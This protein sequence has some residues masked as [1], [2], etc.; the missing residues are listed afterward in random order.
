[1][2][3]SLFLFF[4]GLLGA[5]SG[6]T[7]SGRRPL[8]APQRNPTIRCRSR[9]PRDR[10]RKGGFTCVP[11]GAARS[12]GCALS[13]LLPSQWRRRCRW[14]R[15]EPRHRRRGRGSRRPERHEHGGRVGA[16]R[17]AARTTGLTGR[18]TSS[19][20]AAARCVSRCGRRARTTGRD[21]SRG[22]EGLDRRR[23]ARPQRPAACGRATGTVAR[24]SRDG[25]D[26]HGHERVQGHVRGVRASGVRDLRPQDQPRVRH[27]ER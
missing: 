27:V 19:S 12:D 9:S 21:L 22:H 10:T 5:R 13:S 8:Q 25:R 4:P 17:C 6:T 18:W 20:R 24:K 16:I 26:G 3:R 7:F 15:R 1:M 2:R 14:Y 23:R 11:L